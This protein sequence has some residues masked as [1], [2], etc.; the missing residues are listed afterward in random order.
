M[1][2]D[3]YPIGNNK[4]RRKRICLHVTYRLDIGQTPV[5]FEEY[6][7]ITVFRCELLKLID[8]LGDFHP[9]DTP[10]ISDAV[11]SDTVDY[12]MP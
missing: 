10:V 3:A 7:E 4:N 11:R 5:M 6:V 9:A 12:S 8:Q 1:K 2:I